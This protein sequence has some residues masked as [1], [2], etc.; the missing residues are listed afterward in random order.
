MRRGSPPR[1]PRGGF[2]RGFQAPHRTSL[3]RLPDR[4]VLDDSYNASPDSMTSALELLG[5]LP[6]R[7]VAVLGEMMEL[8]EGTVPG[9]LEVGRRAAADADRLLVVGAGAGAIAD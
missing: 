2:A 5:T 3:V 8:G 1:T 4:L 6:G 7:K 9:H